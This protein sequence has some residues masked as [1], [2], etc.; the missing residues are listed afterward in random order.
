MKVFV[1]C[2]LVLTIYLDSVSSN[3]LIVRH[4]R[5][6]EREGDAPSS[7]VVVIKDT[8]GPKYDFFPTLFG[9]RNDTNFFDLDINEDDGTF[10]FGGQL[11]HFHSFHHMHHS[12]QDIFDSIQ[13]RFEGKSSFLMSCKVTNIHILCPLSIFHGNQMKEMTRNM[14]RF[15]NSFGPA[16]RPTTDVAS[17]PDNTNK[18]DT[19]IVTLNGRRYLKKTTTIKKGGPGSSL[20]VRSVTFEPVND[21]ENSDSESETDVKPVSPTPDTPVA[22]EPLQPQ[23]S[24]GKRVKDEVPAVESSSPSTSS[25]PAVDQRE[26]EETSSPSS[27]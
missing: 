7:E 26:R 5:E 20:F 13:R 22:G 19:E 24:D 23:E 11:P 14:M 6:L 2:F 10:N 3:R 12:F 15:D 18:T 4:K 16:F 21:L 8:Q 9:N 1:L 25:S 27:S 17:I